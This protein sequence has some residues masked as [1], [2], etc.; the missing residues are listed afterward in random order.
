MDSLL[1]L[2]TNEVE[3]VADFCL[4]NDIKSAAHKTSENLRP[5]QNPPASL[6]YKEVDFL[7]LIFGITL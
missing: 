4:F 2:S 5:R 6:G 3:N 1:I 7:R